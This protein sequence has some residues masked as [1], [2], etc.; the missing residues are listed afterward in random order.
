MQKCANCAWRWKRFGKSYCGK[1]HADM[2]VKLS[3]VCEYFAQIVRDEEKE[4]SK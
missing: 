3:D 4:M 2:E 1:N